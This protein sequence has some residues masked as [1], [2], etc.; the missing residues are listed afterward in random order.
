MPAQVVD[1]YVIIAGQASVHEAAYHPEVMAELL[2]RLVGHSCPHQLQF[3]S[4]LPTEAGQLCCKGAICMSLAGEL[5][6]D[7]QLT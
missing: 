2:E 5:V 4:S 7:I 6:F 3:L 1:P